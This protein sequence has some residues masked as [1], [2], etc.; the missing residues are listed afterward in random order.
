MASHPAFSPV[1]PVFPLRRAAPLSLF[2]PLLVF[3]RRAPVS[4]S[5]YD[6]SSRTIF[7]KLKLCA[8]CIDYRAQI[9]PADSQRNE[10]RSFP[11]FQFS[12]YYISIEIA[13]RSYSTRYQWISLSISE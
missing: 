7:D 1:L 10:Y 9:T 4:H 11:F 3:H 5:L 8:R 6:F 12:M 2:N 13:A